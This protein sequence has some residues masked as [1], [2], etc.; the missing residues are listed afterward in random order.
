LVH[1][2]PKEYIEGHLKYTNSIEGDIDEF[3]QV[4]KIFMD[5]KEVYVAYFVGG[6]VNVQK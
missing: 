5:E 1:R 4:E 6:R 2:G 3:R